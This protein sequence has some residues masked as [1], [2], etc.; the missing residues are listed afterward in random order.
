[1]ACLRSGGGIS[2]LDW[3]LLGIVGWVLGVLFVLILMRMAGE[4]DRSARHSQRD[5]DPYADVTI[6]RSGR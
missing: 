5:I 6:T 3:I 2:K 1:M 4:Q